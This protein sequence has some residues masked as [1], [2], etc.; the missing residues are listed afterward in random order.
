[1]NTGKTAHA[2]E[3]QEIGIFKIPDILGL[4]PMTIVYTGFFNAIVAPGTVFTPVYNT[5]LSDTRQPGGYRR[6]FDMIFFRHV[7]FSVL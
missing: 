7:I 3:K 4:L 2:F 1:L 6:C 5:V